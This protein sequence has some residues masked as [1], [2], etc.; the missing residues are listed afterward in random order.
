MGLVVEF[1]GAQKIPVLQVAKR[2]ILVRSLRKSQIAYLNQSFEKYHLKGLWQGYAILDSVPEFLEGVV[3]PPLDE[4]RIGTA[5]FNSVSGDPFFLFQDHQGVFH[6]LDSKGE[7]R[8]T[9]KRL[10][11]LI[12]EFHKNKFN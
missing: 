11:S 1:T 7:I 10:K 12:K 8:T 5:L 2:P 4:K 6:L 9:H 3:Q